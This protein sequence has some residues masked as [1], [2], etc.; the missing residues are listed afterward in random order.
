MRGG[1]KRPRRAKQAGQDVTIFFPD[2]G[3]GDCLLHASGRSVKAWDAVVIDAH[4][5]LYPPEVNDDPPGWALVAEEPNWAT[6]CTRRRKNGQAV[7]SFPRVDELLREMDRVGVGRAVL[8]GWYWER[9]D[10]CALQNRFYAAC[11]RAHPDRLSAFATLQP[12]AGRATTLT[13]MKRAREEGLVG[14]GELS[15]H[16]QRYELAN[17][18]LAAALRLAGEWRWPV[19]LHVTD[20][21]SGGYPGRVETPL[22]DFVQVAQAWPQVDF[23]LAHWGGL[24]PLRDA[25]AAK[26]PNLFYDTAASPLMYDE[27][28]WKRFLAVVP[29]ERVLF[30]SDFPL[31][32]FPKESATP[33]MGRLLAEAIA[34]GVE[35]NILHHNA[36]RLLRL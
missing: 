17:E 13:E 19:N 36:A 7:Q 16:A 32:L 12:A 15:P 14:L 6:L 4:V 29:E 18:T 24:L 33:E 21:N 1:V 23:I 11:V 9:A 2:R 28:V 22:E 31:N 35:K 27:S 10:N 20:P 3:A 8:L 5:H 26:M 30:G 34:A 25:G